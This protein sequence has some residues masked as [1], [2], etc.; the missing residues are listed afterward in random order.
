[1][2]SREARSNLKREQDVILA[3]IRG[4]GDAQ[5]IDLAKNIL[6][7]LL[8]DGISFPLDVYGEVFVRR[9]YNDLLE[10]TKLPEFKS[11]IRKG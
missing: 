2:A 5:R 11:A 3:R 6:G 10:Y 4:M 1:M 7:D 9:A 8:S